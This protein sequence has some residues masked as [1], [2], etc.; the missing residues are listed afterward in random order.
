MCEAIERVLVVGLG[1][2]GKRHV[3]VIHRVYPNIKI[4]A[5]KHSKCNDL[6]IEKL[7]LYKCVT[8]IEE[9]LA[10][11]PQAAIV[12]NPAVPASNLAMQPT[13]AR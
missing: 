3:Q 6:E 5:L 1:S 9:A 7:K 10:F 4:I 2:I 12:A 13:E 8:K 11:Q